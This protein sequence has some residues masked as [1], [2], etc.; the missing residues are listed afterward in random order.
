MRLANRGVVK[1]GNWADVTIFDLGALSDRATYE[2]PR[3]YPSGIDWVLVNGVI[4]VDHGKH[5]GAKAGK[6]LYGPGH[7]PSS[8]GASQ[9]SCAR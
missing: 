8:N 1:E 2:K 3:E 7:E 6:V 9:S 5:T 4:T